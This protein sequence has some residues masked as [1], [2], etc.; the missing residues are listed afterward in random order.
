MSMENKNNMIKVVIDITKR[1]EKI[2]P[3]TK[4]SSLNV[5]ELKTDYELCGL[6]QEALYTAYDECVAEEDTASQVKLCRIC[7]NTLLPRYKR[8]MGVYARNR[9]IMLDL[10]PKFRAAYAFSARRSMLHFAYFMEWEKPNKLWSKTAETMEVAFKYADKLI[11]D[12][13]MLFYRLSCMPGL[14]KTYLVNL[15]VANMLGNDANLTII[16]VSYADDN[17]KTSTEQIKNIMTQDAYKEVFPNYKGFGSVN[18]QYSFNLEESNQ[19]INYTGVTR[20]GQLSGKRGKVVIY[21]DILKGELEA[22]NK[23]LCDQVYQVMVGDAES[24]ADDDK[25]KTITIGTIRSIF[26]P[27]LRQVDNVS[28]HWRETG[29]KYAEAVVDE[30]NNITAVSIAIPALDYDTDESTIPKRYSTEYLRKQRTKLG[31]SFAALYQQ[32]PK[33]IEGLGFSW[34]NLKK[35]DELPQG[36]PQ[37]V[38]CFADPPRKGKDYFA[39]PILYNYGGN[40]WYLVDAVFQRRQSKE[41]IELLVDKINQ[42]RINIF[43]YEN[44]VDTSLDSLITSRMTLVGGWQAII[45]GEYTYQNK[46]TKIMNMSPNLKEFIHFPHKDAIYDNKQLSQYI[47]QLTTYSFDFP[48]KFDD[49][50]DSMSMFVAKFI[51]PESTKIAATVRPLDLRKIGGRI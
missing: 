33:P 4:E 15:M 1:L 50:I 5:K 42:H 47:E 17:V 3:Y 2:Y 35:Y 29:D 19:G 49:A 24:R 31:D 11:A 20:F 37:Q 28:Q 23:S 21:D 6:L 46:E 12:D 22:T 41:L 14:G 13:N 51:S 27:M 34:G 38:C 26:D 10:Y 25:Q 9:K 39:M 48:N 18:T 43:A 32:R 8:L 30:D 44:N 45:V 40:N 36:K 7:A 16:R